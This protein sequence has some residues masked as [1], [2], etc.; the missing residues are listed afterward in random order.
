MEHYTRYPKVLEGYSDSNWISNADE[1][2]AT[3]DYVFTH[4]GGA[5][6]WKS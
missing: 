3:S 1:I 4:G 5:V 2:K 6:S